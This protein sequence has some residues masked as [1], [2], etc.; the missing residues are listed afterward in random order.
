MKWREKLG[1]AFLSLSLIPWGL[2]IFDNWS[3]LVAHLNLRDW[4]MIVLA[5]LTA[6]V[7]LV[8]LFA[9]A[10]KGPPA[11]LTA[12]F[13]IVVLSWAVDL[14]LIGKFGADSMVPAQRPS[15]ARLSW[16]SVAPQMQRIG[17][18]VAAGLL[19]ESPKP[20]YPPA[21]KTAGAYGVVKLRVRIGCDGHV[22]EASL[23]S[24]HPL[25]VP[26]AIDAVMGYVYKPFMLNGTAV[27]V[28]TTVKVDFGSEGG[29]D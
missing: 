10:P 17:E 23:V 5:H 19:Q 16:V 27:D 8:S 1:V 29:R 15:S 22:A 2:E 20:I 18:E 14:S 21:A 9:E 26:A 12:L 4:I 24:G 3:L 11:R 28:I 13:P 7:A 25:L 6:L